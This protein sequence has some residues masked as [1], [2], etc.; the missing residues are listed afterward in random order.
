MK[1]TPHINNPKTLFAEG[2]KFG[3]ITAQWNGDITA[4]LHKGAYDTLLWLGASEQNIHSWEV[5]GSF[6]L[7]YAANKLCRHRNLD[8][9]IVIGSI[10]KG[11][12]RHFEYLCKAVS[13]GIK[14]INI[15]NDTP[16]IFCVL[17]D[18]YKQQSI[19][20]SGGKAGNKGIECAESAIKM[21][22]FRKFLQSS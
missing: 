4:N 20:R 22:L 1:I 6:E 11:D 2:L 9:M 8:A 15:K 21:A 13:Q 3:L 7:I 19:D 5:P 14:D 18:E 10:I 12:T 17:T 16:V